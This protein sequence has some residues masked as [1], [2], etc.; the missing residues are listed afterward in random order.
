METSG[1]SI[2]ATLL[3]ARGSGH[4]LLSQQLQERGSLAEGAGS[5]AWAAGRQSRRSS[6]AEALLFSSR[7]IHRAEQ[8][9]VTVILTELS[10][11]AFA[12]GVSPE[13]DACWGKER[14][15]SLGGSQAFSGVGAWQLG[16]GRV[17]SILPLAPAFSRALQ[18]LSQCA[19]HRAHL[20]MLPMPFVSASAL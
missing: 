2:L 4:C 13:R 18:I 9:D 15:L 19:G 16:L 20:Y 8:G 5:A 14:P 6:L 1:S 3:S 10:W 12:G 17:F 7:G 11:R